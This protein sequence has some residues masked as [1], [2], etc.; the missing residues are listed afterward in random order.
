MAEAARG[1]N[2]SELLPWLEADREALPWPERREVVRRL[3]EE[4]AAASPSESQRKLVNLL[5]EDP[6]W[7]VRQDIADLL[8]MLP[9]KDFSRLQ[10]KLASDANAYVRA[11][12][13][14]AQER[15]ERT[16]QQ[17]QRA[18]RGL[19]AVLNQLDIF[20]RQHGR[21]ARRKAQLL[22]EEYNEVVVGTMLHDLRSI[23]THLKTNSEPIITQVPDEPKARK[24]AARLADDLQLLERMLRDMEA[25]S[26]P[27]TVKRQPER[28]SD[29]AEAA[30]EMAQA[31]LAQDGVDTEPVRVRLD[32]PD[33][34][35]FDV[36]RHLLMLALSNVIKNAFEAYSEADG[37]LR[38]GSIHISA[39]LDGKLV[40]IAVQ[41]KGKGFSKEERAAYDASLP[42]RMNKTKRHSTG[43]GLAN[44]K[45]YIQAHEG[46]VEIETEENKGTTVTIILPVTG[47]SRG[48]P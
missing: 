23:M 15:R 14:R 13:E 48:V 46:R 42:G 17:I 36:V 11:A 35:T 30:L 34:L 41:D 28:V 47:A 31:G 1:Q 8:L 19:G 22:C 12:A 27:L 39:A 32:V 25:F 45:R 29:V 2:L 21:P 38:V 43:Y 4:L 26:K 16:E 24:A 37:K 33:H 44:A 9:P 7:E 40:R 3:A 6:K 5:A 20:E 18:N 10:G